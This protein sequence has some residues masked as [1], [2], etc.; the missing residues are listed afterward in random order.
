MG[1]TKAVQWS[2]F[3]HSKQ[4]L[5]T[6][7]AQ[8]TELREGVESWFQ[9]SLRLWDPNTDERCRHQGLLGMQEGERQVQSKKGEQRKGKVTWPTF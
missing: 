2:E 9:Y 5:S 4:F 8:S 7:Y 3:L 6:Y 1:Q